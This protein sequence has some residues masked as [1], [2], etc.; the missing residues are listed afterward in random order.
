MFLVVVST[1]HLELASVGKPKRLGEDQEVHKIGLNWLTLFWWHSIVRWKKEWDGYDE[2]P[3]GLQRIILGG[4][5]HSP[6]V[7]VRH[8]ECERA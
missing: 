4:A 2:E 1:F 3:N 8:P 5:P 6:W 7:G